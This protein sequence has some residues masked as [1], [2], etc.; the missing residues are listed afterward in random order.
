MNQLFTLLQ[1]APAEA[2]KGGGSMTL[3]F[4]LLIIL[5]FYFF[6]IRPQQKRQKQVEE[7]RKNLQKGDKVTTIGGIHGKIREIK[8]STFVIE[9]AHD[10]CVEVEKA[11]INVDENAAKA[12][13]PATSENS[14]N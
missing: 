7:F 13:A 5:I 1:A 9:I 4:I 6:M 11:A 14:E 12:K 2:P 8:E 3:I 10:V